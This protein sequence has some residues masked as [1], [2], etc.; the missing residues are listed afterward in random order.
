LVEHRV[1]TPVSQHVFGLALGFQELNEHDEL[2]KNPV[3]AILAGKLEPVMGQTARLLRVR[4]HSI[5]L[6]IR[7]SGMAPSTTRSKA[8]PRRHTLLFEDRSFFDGP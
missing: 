1:G 4:A 3:F 2:R 7:P 6:S 5:G 8:T